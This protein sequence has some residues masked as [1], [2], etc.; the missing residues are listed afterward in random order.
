MRHGA[1]SPQISKTLRFAMLAGLVSMT[2][3]ACGDDDKTG[4]CA[5]DSECTFGLICQAEACV[6]LPCAGIA[7]CTSGDQSCVSVN[8][9]QFCAAVECGCANCDVCPVGQV[10][11]AGMC[12]AAASC[13][14]AIPCTG[15]NICDGGSCRACT[16]AEC[17]ADC[18]VAGC[19]GSLV[20]NTT[21]KVCEAGTE[22]EACSSCT[23]SDECGVGWKCV[24]LLSGNACLPPCQA[25]ADCPSGWDC[26]AQACTPESYKCTG[27]AVEG[28]PNGQSCNPTDNSYTPTAASCSTCSAD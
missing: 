25:K 24:P 12:G 26:Q 3:V 15:S 14:E 9:G 11:A 10:C 16:G 22:I 27:C 1:T 4:K 5:T 21:T 17:P 2:L 13:S 6:A 19:T 18:T 7:D 8:D 23:R 20:C 28:C